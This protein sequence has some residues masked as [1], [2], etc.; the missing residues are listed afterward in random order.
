MRTTLLLFCLLSFCFSS[1]SAQAEGDWYGVLD[2]MGTKLPM[3]VVFTRSD[4]GWAGTLFDPTK[5]DRR[6]AMTA[7]TF[8]GQKLGFT[9]EPLGITYSGVVDGKELRG[10][11]NQA[12]IDFPLTFTRHRPE[13][14][15]V[16]EGPITIRKREQEPV[17]FPY[18]RQAVNFPG[19]T[20][21][22]TLAG[23]LTVPESSKPK[24]L[25][26]LVS[27]SGPQDRNSY[28]G[29]QINHSPFLVL[30]DYLTRRGYGVLRYDERGVAKSTGDFAAA[31]TADLAADAA[32]AVR[33]L[34]HVTGIKKV[35]IGVLGHSEGGIIAPMVAA[36][37][38]ELDFVVLL[39]APGVPIDSLMLEQRRAVGRAMGF[40]PAVIDRETPT[41]RAGYRFIK[42]S[43]LLDQ[44]QYVDGLYAVFEEQ[45]NNLPEP[46]R[47]SI[48]EPRAFNAQYVKPLSSPWMRYFIAIDPQDYLRRLTVP[49]LAVNGTKDVQVPAMM[50][51]NAISRALAISGNEDATVLPLLELNHLLQ[52]ADTGAP[53]EYGTIETT[54]DPS[55][56]ETIGSWLDERF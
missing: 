47:K 53:S 7:V 31:T 16:E 54:L 23:E 32:A 4:G 11:F 20:E 35:A 25:L 8:A 3:K 6:I 46:L 5:P 38:D 15:P 9:A 41:W 10:V 36:Q 55:A 48:K 28:F 13:G 56:L 14:Y 30:S 19:G 44:D 33:Y 37:D 27:G 49:V 17:E 29:S 39:A 18:V 1:L 2:A 34:H 26:V 43:A 22:V 12:N 42:E 40:P 52:P 24:A 21:G 45:M 51:L 50:N